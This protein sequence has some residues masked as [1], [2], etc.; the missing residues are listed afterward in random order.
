MIGMCLAGR[1]GLW[2][3]LRIS[4]LVFLV[5]TMFLAAVPASSSA[6]Q[7]EQVIAVVR[8]VHA[9]T[10]SAIG[11][12][13]TN[14]VSSIIERHVDLNA[15]AG[16]MLG[17]TW[18]AASSSE[19]RDFR[20]VLRDI[21][22][23][24]LVRKVRGGDRFTIKGAKAIG[25]RDTVVFSEQSLRGGGTRKLDWKLRP[26]GSSF[27]IYDLVLNGASMTI[28]RRDEFAAR[29]KSS[30]GSL[31]ALTRSLRAELASSR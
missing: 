15:V 22:A 12:K 14:R 10:V 7:N 27:C 25:A 16:R 30:G 19:R 11:A 31:G 26:C 5:A 20:N 28:A 9:Q 23:N 17:K 4:G 29:L 2:K 13:R 6:A 18:Q 8:S 21:V 24:E 3:V 1:F